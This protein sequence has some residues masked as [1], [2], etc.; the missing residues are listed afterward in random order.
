MIKE[1]RSRVTFSYDER[2]NMVAKVAEGKSTFYTYDSAN[3]LTK[4]ELAGEDE[5]KI[6]EYSYD[7]LGNRIGRAEYEIAAGIASQ[8]KTSQYLNDY[9]SPLTQVLQVIDEKGKIKS[10]TYGLRRIALFDEKERADYFLYDGLGSV[11]GLVNHN[12]SLTAKYTYDEFGI[13]SPSSK[14]GLGGKRENAFGF[15]GEDYDQTVGLLYLRARYYAPEVGRFISEDPLPGVLFEPRSQNRFSYVLNNPLSYVDKTGL[16]PK[17]GF[18]IS[19]PIS[20]AWVT[21]HLFGMI[22]LETVISGAV[23]SGGTDISVVTDL[24]MKS[25]AISVAGNRYKIG[26]MG[27]FSVTPNYDSGFSVVGM[28]AIPGGPFGSYF[29]VTVAK[30]IYLIQESLNIS[31]TAKITLYVN[32][33]TPLYSIESVLIG[34]YAAK[35]GYAGVFLIVKAFTELMKGSVPRPIP[36]GP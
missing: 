21:P 32:T 10:F 28:G 36:A 18:G 8:K 7:G 16:G 9:S 2:G 5:T 24:T 15:T 3:R 12:A 25:I 20:A 13:P 34:T 19:L 11:V 4:V 17:L 27:D 14:F 1:D 26:T 33:W 35:L 30:T 22:I 6:V 29:Y 31:Y 23:S